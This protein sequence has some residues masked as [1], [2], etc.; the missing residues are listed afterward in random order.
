MG[1]AA[2]KKW[3]KKHPQAWK[4]DRAKQNKKY[5]DKTAWAKNHKKQWSV[6]EDHLVLN[7]PGT[8][9]TLGESLG[10]SVRAI[11]VRRCNLGGRKK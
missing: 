7:H 5:Y 10:R 2:N 6:R 8:D 11:Q 3:R 9:S 1:Y 4:K